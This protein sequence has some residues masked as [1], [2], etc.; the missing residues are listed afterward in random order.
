MWTWSTLSSFVVRIH[1]LYVRRFAIAVRGLDV[2]LFSGNRG[3]WRQWEQLMEL[4]HTI[5]RKGFVFCRRVFGCCKQI[6]LSSGLRPMKWGCWCS[7]RIGRAV[8]HDWHVQYLHLS[9]DAKRWSWHVLSEARCKVPSRILN[10]TGVHDRRSVYRANQILRR[11]YR[12]IIVP[13][14]LL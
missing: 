14:V 8:F 7:K 3:N 10:Q 5:I 11:R 1:V 4:V 9:E 13:Y 6:R 2:P 12:C